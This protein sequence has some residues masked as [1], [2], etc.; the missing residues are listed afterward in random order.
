MNRICAVLAFLLFSLSFGAQ[1]HA[2]T[3]GADGLSWYTDVN[4]AHQESLK[5]K[6]PIFGFFTGSDWCYWCKKLQNEVFSKPEFVAWAKKSVVLLELDFPRNKQLPQELASQNASLQQAF[7]VPGY[8][9]IWIFNLEQG[10]GDKNFNIQP[11]G[12]LGYPSGA[13]AGKEEV[14]FLQNAAVIMEAKAPKV[15]ETPK[16]KKSKRA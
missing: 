13:E 11:W 8:P 5:S 15:E 12:S 2:Q 3:A 10:T 1:S 9:T 6:K 7:Q 16:K 4:K 14:K